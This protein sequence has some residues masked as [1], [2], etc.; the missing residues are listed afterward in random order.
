MKDW[1]RKG[2]EE[3][4]V[5]QH[6]ETVVLSWKALEELPFVRQCFSTRQ[7]GVSEGFLATMNFSFDR[8]DDPEHVRENYRRIAETIGVP[9]DS[10]VVAHQTHT[11]NILVV[12]KEDRGTGVLR[13]RPYND[14]DGLMTNAPGVTLVTYHADCIP[15]WL[16]D[17]YR[18]AAALL[19]AGWKGTVDGI[20][21]KAAGMMQEL[22]GTKPEDLIACAGPGICSS[23]YEIGEDVAARFREVFTAEEL[24]EILTDYHEKEDG[25][26]WQLDLCQANRVL[27]LRSGIK[28]HNIHISDICTR[29][30]AERLFSH[31][32]HGVRRGLNAAFLGIFPEGED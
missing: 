13:P 26:H 30:N 20:A 1:I 15:V 6:G 29:C 12:G 22:Y 8:G 11:T 14:I 27:L 3:L 18:K 5:R 17:P 19:H 28:P 4:R 7:G 9:A 2:T 16:V 31:R 24:E 10:F 25:G 32:A 23:C 21:P